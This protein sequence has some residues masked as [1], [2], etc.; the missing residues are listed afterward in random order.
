MRTCLRRPI[1]DRNGAINLTIVFPLPF[2]AEE[3]H[4]SALAALQEAADTKAEAAAVLA[5]RRAVQ[6][7]AAELVAQEEGMEQWKKD[8]RAEAMRHIEEREAVL[9]EWEERLRR[10]ESAMDKKQV[11]LADGA[12]SNGFSAVLRPFATNAFEKRSA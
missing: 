5:E 7:R 8:V 2:Q 9:A 12:S 1:W 3:M 6:T 11:G 4:A 10:E